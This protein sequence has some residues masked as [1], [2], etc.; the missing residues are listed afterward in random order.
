[1]LLAEYKISVLFQL[2]IS[3]VKYWTSDNL[4][5]RVRIAHQMAILGPQGNT[6]SDYRREKRPYNKPI[7]LLNAIDFS[8]RLS[9]G[10]PAARAGGC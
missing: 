7:L 9:L 4:Q 1:M 6:M 2:I 8:P 5:S 10:R 3:I